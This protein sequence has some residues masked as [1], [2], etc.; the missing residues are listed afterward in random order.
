MLVCI[1]QAPGRAVIDWRWT[2]LQGKG[3]SEENQ[4]R[5]VQREYMDVAG[6]IEVWQQ[7]AI[8]P[9]M[10]RQVIQDTRYLNNNIERLQQLI[11]GTLWRL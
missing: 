2:N 3:M 7:T 8:T 4:P 5:G 9:R 1:L 10:A 11:M 6:L